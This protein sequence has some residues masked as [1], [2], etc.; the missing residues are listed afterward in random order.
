MAVESAGYAHSQDGRFGAKLASASAPL[1][2]LSREPLV[3]FLAL[4]LLIFMVAHLVQMAKADHARR[5]VVDAA[6]ERRLSGLQALQTGVPPTRGELD[7]LTRDYVRDETLYRTALRMGLD[8][9]DEIIRRRLVQKMEFLL[10]D[11]GAAQ[12]PDESTLRAFFQARPELFAQPGKVT[13]S[14]RFFDPGQGGESAALARARAALAAA[15][16]R[17]GDSFPLQSAYADLDRTAAL[18]IFGH[19]QIVD[20]LFS[21]PMGRWIGPVRSGYGWHL[22]RV[23]FRSPDTQPRFESVRDDVRSAWL[24][25]VR[26]SERRK[27]LQALLGQYQVVRVPSGAAP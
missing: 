3:Q 24:A 8:R 10:D 18:Q 7:S 21:R 1:R 23:E 2:A 14:H 27:R 20:A 25:D 4:G 11:S 9:G 19:T 12:E 6:L 17:A 16:S 26:D 5:I 13:F 15:D 22:I